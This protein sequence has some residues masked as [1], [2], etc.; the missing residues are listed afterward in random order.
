MRVCHSREP[1]PARSVNMWCVSHV[2][3]AEICLI[4]SLDLFLKRAVECEVVYIL[5]RCSHQLYSIVVTWY[6][7]HIINSNLTRSDCSWE[8]LTQFTGQIKFM[9]QW[10]SKYNLCISMTSLLAR[11]HL[12]SPA[13][14]LFTQPLIREQIKENIKAPLLFV[15]GIHWSWMNFPHKWPETRIMFPFDD[16]IM[17]NGARFPIGRHLFNWR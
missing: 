6:I 15:Q 13:S 4:C 1:S 10:V 16:V 7:W 11:C 3:F 2:C 12:K 17:W 9:F 5:H 14:R 8:S